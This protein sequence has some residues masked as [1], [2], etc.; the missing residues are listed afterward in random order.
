MTKYLVGIAMLTDK[1]LKKKYVEEF[2]KNPDKYYPSI[3]K[4]LGFE[5]KQCATCRRFF[6]SIVKRQHCGDAQCS[7]GYTFI[8]ST[9]AKA[10]MDYAGFWQRFSKILSEQGYKPVRRYPVVAR[11]RDDIPFVE[12]SIDDFIPYVING[13]VEPPA[14]PLVIPQPCLR[15]NDIDNVGITGAHYTCFIMVGQHRFEPPERYDFN[16]Y[17][18]HL[19]KWFTHGMKM[20]QQEIILHEDVWAGSGNFGPC[21]EF[22]SRG[23]EL[24]NQV[25]MQFKQTENGYKDLSLKVL[26]MGLGYERNVWFS[27]GEATSYETTFPSV[28][29][30]LK[31]VTGIK[32]DRDITQRFL[33]YASY[34]NID[35]IEDV[36]KT[37]KVVAGKISIDAK[38]LKDKILPLAALYSI[39]EHTRT[40]LLAITDGGLPSNVG[41]GYNLRIILR[42]ALSFMDNYGWGIELA[43]LC[44]LHAAYLKKLF[45][46]L[47]ENAHLVSSVL[48]EEIRKYNGTKEKS[49]S[50]VRGLVRS[51]KPIT[52]E[53]LVEL[54]DSHGITPEFIQREA[55]L[56]GKGVPVPEDF[57]GKIAERHRKSVYTR[58]KLQIDLRGIPH[59]RL[60]FYE[61]RFMKEFDAKVLRV[62]D[63]KYVILDQT[64][65]YGKSGGQDCDT[66]EINGCRVYNAE[67]L[68]GAIVHFVENPNFAE[69]DT[70]HGKIDWKRREQLMHHHSA[71]H[72]VNGAAKKILG[73]H[74]WQAGASKTVEKATLDIT[75]YK[76]ITD[77]EME[78]LEKMSNDIVRKKVHVNKRVMNR[79]DAEK[80]Y[81]MTVYQGG[82]IPEKHL[83]IMDISGFDVE[84][85]GGTH[86]DNTAEIGQIILVSTER[87]QDGIVRITLVSGNAADLYRQGKARLVDEIK[88][89]LGVEKEEIAS[90]A[91][92]LFTKWKTMRKKIEKATEQK[93]ANVVSEMENKFVNNV[94]IEKLENLN[95]RSLQGVSRMLSG[96]NRTI[97]LFGL[98]DKIYVFGSAGKNTGTDI[99]RIVSRICKELGGNGGGSA[100][101]A[102]GIGARKDR[103]DSV[104]ETLRKELT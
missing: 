92:R 16:K 33:P 101:L 82:A 17:F 27:R 99:G 30:K 54:Y 56:Q 50:I 55:Q 65:F 25:Y 63:N 102:Q 21:I 19:M 22:F 14:N 90:A 35:E 36:E 24:A 42:R 78:K 79:T 70:V 57:Y 73:N 34:L 69:G 40:L 95:M 38:E 61:D 4:E 91:K 46:E 72:V 29:R 32:A 1:E 88:N 52:E 86:V 74:V 71:V 7:G 15:F 37:W 67:K 58:E 96:D 49:A 41:G 80:E 53:K 3:M 83:R 98:A 76:P 89:I 97:I 60:L 18:L 2:R 51:G 81:G 64:C 11:W 43:K 6:W 59:T 23:L 26:D 39:A 85:C 103:L 93:A 77:D 8:G 12:A 28:I 94:L 84:A 31:A 48:D 47:K 100:A 9:P 104:I 20:K 68:G 10:K 5:R 13:D 44:E 75:H 45:P 87:I 62:I 66:G